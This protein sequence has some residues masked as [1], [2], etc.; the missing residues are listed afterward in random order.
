[1]LFL[2]ATSSKKPDVQNL[3]FD[4]FFHYSWRHSWLVAN[5]GSL[6][7][8]RPV[9]CIAQA[10]CCIHCP[11]N[12]EYPV[13]CQYKWPTRIIFRAVLNR[14]WHRLA[15]LEQLYHLELRQLLRVS[16]TDGRTNDW[17]LLK[18]E[19]KPNL[20]QAVK[21]RKLTFCGHILRKEGSSMEKEKIQGTTPGQKVKRKTEG[22]LAW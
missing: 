8:M 14:G 15:E 12:R 13:V 9:V 21:T 18:A 3:T 2:V 1:M 10:G 17:V 16:W 20:L 6:C 11:V 4:L 5:C 7:V 19:T 22:A